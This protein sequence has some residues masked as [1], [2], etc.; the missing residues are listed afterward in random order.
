MKR[1]A[2]IL[3][4][5]AML[6]PIAAWADGIDLTNRFGTVLFTN[7]GVVSKGSQLQS[8]N[9]IFAPPTHA[10]G[11]VKFSTGALVSGDL[12]NGGTF[13]S[14]G[15]S[16]VVTSAGGGYGQPPKGIIFSG[17]FVGPITW[18]LVNH[19]GTF[20]YVF[21]LSGTIKGQLWNGRTVSGTTTQTIYAEK[22]QWLHDHQ[23]G[24]HAGSSNLA[25]P[26]PGTL[27]LMGT[28][29]LGVI[30]SMRRKLFNL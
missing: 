7:A 4:I 24:V 20:D 12:W 22:N 27:G 10:L 23:G 30:G 25:V 18:T 15:S 2:M 13:S 26:E 9:G 1:L 3:G 11:S 17:T 28:G 21:T 5:W 19:P 16:F 29:L 14:V 8:F 6:M